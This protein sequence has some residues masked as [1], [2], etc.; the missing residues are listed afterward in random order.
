MN[1]EPL[2]PGSRL[3]LFF[4]E[5]SEQTARRVQW[6]VLAIAFAFY[7][8]TL[9][10][11]TF[12]L[13][14]AQ[15]QVRAMNGWE[16]SPDA[17]RY[18]LFTFL[19]RL[20]VRPWIAPDRFAFGANLMN[21][22]FGA[23][24][25]MLL[26]RLLTRLQASSGAAMVGAF[27]FMTAHTIWYFSVVTEVYALFH[28]L[29]LACLLLAVQW[30]R[31]Q[32]GSLTVFLF[33]FAL[34][35][36][37]H[38]MFLLV[39]PALALYL[40]LKRREVAGYHWRHGALAFGIG[41]LPLLIVA[42]KYFFTGHSPGVLAHDYLFSTS[43]VWKNTLLY[44]ADIGTTRSVVY[45]LVF[46][47]YNFPS[48]ALVLG[49][50]GIVTTLLRRTK[51][52]WLLL[53]LAEITLL[54]SLNY[55]VEDKWAFFSSFYLVYA[56]YA[57]IGAQT[58][59]TRFCRSSTAKG[60]AL[61]PAILAATA[62][63]PVIFYTLTPMLL[64]LADANPFARADH[65][66]YHRMFLNP[67][68]AGDDEAEYFATRVYAAIEPDAKLFCEAG[69]C[70]VLWY[71]N[72][73]TKQG[74]GVKVFFLDSTEPTYLRQALTDYGENRPSYVVLN[75]YYKTKWYDNVLSVAEPCAADLPLFAVK[76][77]L[78]RRGLPD[79]PAALRP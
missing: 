69:A 45:Y 75:P 76:S 24:S 61:G 59:F 31:E 16:L 26:F 37:H 15:L 73:T 64:N 27:S 17:R 40:T 19:L 43:D 46:F 53:V 23:L 67:N 39:V 2:D 29:T 41:L 62:V 77:S 49:L 13:D 48:P 42:I 3:T 9:A 72:H 20:L 28:A 25:V 70:S 30:D 78:P 7:F 10:P 6:L 35:L 12:W 71:V 22:L 11:G 5:A 79:P 57:G 66:R 63:L 50:V 33:L 14:S 36:S 1:D 18:P 4:T 44:T 38:R 56:I 8:L 51:E 52:T 32:P 55:D 65:R 74:R 47:I 60:L 34:A 54:F 58:I 21:A 68:R